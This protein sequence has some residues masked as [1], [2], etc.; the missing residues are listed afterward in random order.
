MGCLASACGVQQNDPIIV[1]IKDPPQGEVVHGTALLKNAQLSV[2]DGCLRIIPS[3][4]SGPGYLAVFPY[5]FSLR[6][7]ED[8]FVVIDDQGNVWGRTTAPKNIGGGVGAAPAE[9]F[10]PMGHCEGPQWI[11]GL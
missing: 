4:G 8:G 7:A 10:T 2:V 9:V 3:T 1:T 11:V 6:E 5:G